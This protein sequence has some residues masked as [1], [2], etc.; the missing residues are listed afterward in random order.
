MATR[1]DTKI[2]ATQEAF[3]RLLASGLSIKEAARDMDM[4]ET[5]LYRWQRK[6]IIRAR[7][8]ELRREITEDAVGKLKSSL[9]LAVTILVDVAADTKAPPN[10]RVNAAAK[11]VDGA[12]KSLETIEIIERLAALE[13]AAKKNIEEDADNE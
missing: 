9:H 11:I 7:I 6:P 2:T 8:R 12:L 10:V 1:S 5:T 13:E 4:S 3:C